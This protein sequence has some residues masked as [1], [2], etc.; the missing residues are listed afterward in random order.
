VA[1]A[2]KTVDRVETLTVPHLLANSDLTAT[3]ARRHYNREVDRV[4]PPPVDVAAFDTTRTRKETQLVLVGRLEERKRPS[5]AVDAMREL[6]KWTLK[7]VGDGPL[8][9][10]LERDAPSNVDFLGFVDDDRLRRTVAESVAGLFLAEREDFG[11]TPVE[12]MAAGT[13]VVGVD[14]PNTNNQVDERTGVLVEPTPAAVADGIREVG[15]RDWDRGEIRRAAAA[16]GAER[17]RTDLRD[18]VEAVTF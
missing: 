13:P 15:R 4:L 5:V 2:I 16:Y 14:E 9:A 1:Y 7:V 17:F 12:Y 3:R 18:F 6:P 11:I 8:R 10:E